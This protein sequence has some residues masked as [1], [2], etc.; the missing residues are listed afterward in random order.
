MDLRTKDRQTDGFANRVALGSQWD[1]NVIRDWIRT[2]FSHELRDCTG[3]T[4]V[5]EQASS[6]F[7]SQLAVAVRTSCSAFQRSK[8]IMDPGLI[9]QQMMGI[10]VLASRF[11]TTTENM[12]PILHLL[13]EN[14]SSWNG[15][16]ES[17]QRRSTPPKTHAPSTRH[18]LCEKPH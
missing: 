13:P 16:S 4:L 5:T 7:A 9:S 3:L 2:E 12:L 15:L 17:G 8:I 10:S 1:W 14:V 11:S 6:V 18:P